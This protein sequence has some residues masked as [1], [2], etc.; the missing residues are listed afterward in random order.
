[1]PW[2]RDE[3]APYCYEDVYH[4]AATERFYYSDVQRTADERN[5]LYRK[6]N[7]RDPS[8]PYRDEDQ[9]SRPRPPAYDPW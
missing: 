6:M 2:S 4:P 8:V 3:V 9:W 7:G 1:M 5:D